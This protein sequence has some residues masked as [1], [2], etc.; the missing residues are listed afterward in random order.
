MGRSP[1]PVTESRAFQHKRRMKRRT[2]LQEIKEEHI[3][4][5]GTEE[6]R[7]SMSFHFQIDLHIILPVLLLRRSMP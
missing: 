3:M 4:K 6:S 7:V 2:K 1:S 5:T